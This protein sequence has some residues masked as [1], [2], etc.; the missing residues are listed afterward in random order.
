MTT[1]SAPLTTTN[2][3][4]LF[5]LPLT[6]LVGIGTG[7]VWP[8]HWERGTGS[9]I[10]EFNVAA[11]ARADLGMHAV[12]TTSAADDIDFIKSSLKLTTT[13]LAKYLGVSR[14][15]IY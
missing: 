3:R 1:R 7:G 11:V 14:Q 2:G 9:S 5:T 6:L 12:G 15:A 4:V 10:N 13:E 8:C